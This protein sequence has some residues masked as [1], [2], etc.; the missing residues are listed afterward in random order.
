MRSVRLSASSLAPRSLAAA[1]CDRPGAGRRPPADPNKVVRWFFPTGEN[2]FDPV[3]ISDLYSATVIEAIFERL[4]TYDYLARPSKVVPHGRRSDAGGHRRRQ[5]VDVQDPEGH[6]LRARS[7]VQ[8]QEARAHRAGLRLFVHAVHGSEASAR[9]TRSCSRARS[10]AWTS[11]PPRR[12][13]PASSTTTP[14]SP[15]WKRSTGYT[16]RFRLKETDYN[17]VY[18]AAHAVARR[19]R[20]RGDRGVPR[21]HDGASGGHRRVPAQE[22]D[23]A[24][25]DRARGQSRVSAVSSGTS[26]RPTTPG[27]RRSSRR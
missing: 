2:G 13:R 22:L 6:P 20:A 7:R 14:R 23:A 15:G 11:S 5:D 18:V 19:R 9:R 16:L 27:T 24:L 12:S 21:R 1:A 25:Q 26:S 4:L 10:S 3:R 17:F 8:G